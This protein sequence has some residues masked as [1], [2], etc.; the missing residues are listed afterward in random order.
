MRMASCLFL[1]L[2]NTVC[3]LKHLNLAN[4][5]RPLRVS[6]HDSNLPL[7]A[8]GLLKKQEEVNAAQQVNQARASFTLAA[9]ERAAIT[10]GSS[11]A[12]GTPKDLPLTTR[13]SPTPSGTPNTLN[14]RVNKQARVQ[15]FPGLK[16]TAGGGFFGRTRYSSRSCGLPGQVRGSQSQIQT[17][18]AVASPP[19]F[20]CGIQTTSWV[21][22][23]G[24]RGARCGSGG[25]GGGGRI[26][27][28][29]SSEEKKKKEGK[30]R[31][32]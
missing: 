26:H 10:E 1:C 20:S 14:K 21:S 4:N 22:L 7:P 18:G 15:N 6:R 2:S 3:N 28:G 17:Q 31:S 25:G 8:Q 16:T 23:A 5:D 11:T 9:P 27:P 19:W 12:M 13:F 24:A 29:R 32:Q 30:R